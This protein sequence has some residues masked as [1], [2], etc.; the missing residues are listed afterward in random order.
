MP[1][2]VSQDCTTVLFKGPY[3]KTKNVFFLCLFFMYYLCESIINLLQCYITHCVNEAP[4]LTVGL[5]NTLDLTNV[6][7]KHNTFICRELTVGDFLCF[8]SWK[9]NKEEIRVAE[10]VKRAWRW[11]HKGHQG[12][13]HIGLVFCGKEFTV[14]DEEPSEGCPTEPKIMATRQSSLSETLG[15]STSSCDFHCLPSIA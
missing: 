11:N 6:L 15:I 3:C 4:R 10:E 9:K 7:L 1:A 5:M 12:P 8:C 2:P 13:G 14:W